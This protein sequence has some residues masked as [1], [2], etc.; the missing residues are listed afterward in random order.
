[1]RLLLE[2]PFLL[3]SCQ[4]DKGAIK[5]VIGGANI[6]CPGIT[7]PGGVLPQVGKNSTIAIKCE[8]KENP[9]AIGYTVMT[10]DEMKTVN[11]GIG[12]EM[13]TYIGDEIWLV[14]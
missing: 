12:I 14:K 7:S 6:M 8:G 9:L 3:P 1:M 4:V 13:I 2:Y 11:K 5:F 10:A